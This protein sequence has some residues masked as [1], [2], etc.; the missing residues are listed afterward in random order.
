MANITNQRL[1]E[2]IQELFRILE[3]HPEGLRAREALD[4][5]AKH[6]KLTEYESGF[7]EGRGLRFDHIVRF[8]TVDTVRA[9]WLVKHN[10]VWTVTEEGLKALQEYPDPL[11]FHRAAARLYRQWRKANKAEQNGTSMAGSGDIEVDEAAV[12][13][14]QNSAVTFEEAEEQAWDAIEAFLQVMPP[15]EVQELIADLLRAMDYFVAWVSPPGKDAGVDIIAHGDPL[16]T[17]GPRIKV[18][19]KRQMQR[20]SLPEL[21]SFI[22]NI[23]QHDSGIF[24]C[25]GGFTKEAEDFARGQETKRIM[26][27][28]M[29]RL[30]DLWIEF[31]PKL[32]DK[33][34]QRLPL[35]PIYFLTPQG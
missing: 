27:I 21:K 25:T 19:V 22:A 11:E 26:L 32:S 29:K 6:V 9:G 17:Q 12:A 16:G 33:A 31:T 15:Y 10:A 24:V 28:D 7:Y 2:L 3:K 14:P 13:S 20:I 34:R 8:A 5:L 4:A 1:G 23:G 30:V 35:T 18:Q